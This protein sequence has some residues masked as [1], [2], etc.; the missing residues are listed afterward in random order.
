MAALSRP[1][2]D[3]KVVMSHYVSWAENYMQCEARLGV[4]GIDLY[5]ARCGVIHTA[6]AD[7]RLSDKGDARKI[8]YAWGNRQTDGPMN[9]LTHLRITNIVFLK[10]EDLLEAFSDGASTFFEDVEKDRSLSLL[11]EDRAEKLFANHANLPG[12]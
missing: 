8:F 12:L 7:S 4:L 9:L 6:T 5:G 2:K 11:V 1:A 10:V 3:K